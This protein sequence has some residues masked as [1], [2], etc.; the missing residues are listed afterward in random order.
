MSDDTTAAM[1]HLRESCAIAAGKV[2]PPPPYRPEIDPFKR[3]DDAQVTCWATGRRH[4]CPECG[5]ATPIMSDGR[6]EWI[7]CVSHGMTV[8]FY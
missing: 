4:P 3:V 6:K 8:V 7:H 2:P 5:A 1:D